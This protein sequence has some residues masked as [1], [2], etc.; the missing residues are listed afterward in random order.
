MT[1]QSTALLNRRIIKGPGELELMKAGHFVP[2]LT[3]HFWLDDQDSI[4]GTLVGYFPNVGTRQ[5]CVVVLEYYPERGRIDKA[6]ILYDQYN[7]NGRCL[8]PSIG[9]DAIWKRDFTIPL[10]TTVRTTKAN[11]KVTDWTK[12]ALAK[13]QWG[14]VGQIVAHHDS[15]GQCYVV[16]HAD[17]TLG[18]YDPSEF[19]GV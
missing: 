12:E 5:M 2:D 3:L 16:Q 10:R 1:S 8:H 14:V 15:H 9:I 6:V 11:P 17:G 4:M 18:A 7:R 19:V 13:R